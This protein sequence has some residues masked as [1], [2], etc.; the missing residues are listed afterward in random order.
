MVLILLNS[1]RK[2]FI[3]YVKIYMQKV[4]PKAALMF[5]KLLFFCIDDDL[6]QIFRHFKTG[7]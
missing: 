6:T 3:N 5:F 2:S 7:K 1:L 4:L